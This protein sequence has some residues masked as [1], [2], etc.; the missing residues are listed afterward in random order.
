MS[1][2]ECRKAR[3][4]EGRMVYL[5]LDNGVRVDDSA[6][7]SVGHHSVWMFVNGDDQFFPVEHVIAIWESQP[8]RAAA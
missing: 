3:K 4:L 8:Y 7:I 2:E 5:A 6:L 1:A